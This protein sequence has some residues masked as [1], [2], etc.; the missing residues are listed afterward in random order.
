MKDVKWVNG[1][2]ERLEPGMLVITRSLN[3]PLLIGHADQAGSASLDSPSTR[4][5]LS[6]EQKE[7]FVAWTWLIQPHELEWVERMAKAHGVGK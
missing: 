5:E 6:A 4:V 2:P 1:A 3:K 7:A